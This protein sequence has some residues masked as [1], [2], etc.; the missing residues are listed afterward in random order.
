MKQKIFLLIGIVLLSI[1]GISI[2]SEFMANHTYYKDMFANRQNW[3]IVIRVMIATIIPLWYIIKTKTFS[4]KRFFV[5]ILPITIL[6]FSLAHTIIKEGIVGGS[7]GFLIL[8]VNSLLLYF[9]GMFFI[10][11]VLALGTWISNRW[12]K[13]KEFRWQEM[14]INFGIGLGI[15][16]LL[17]YVL[18]FVGLFYPAITWI[19]FL[20]L[21]GMIYLMRNKLKEYVPLVASMFEGFNLYNLRKNRWKWIGIILLGVS[22]IY[23]LYGFQLSFIPYSTAWDA[24]HAYMYLPKVLAE[25]AGILRGNVGP[26]SSA[27]GLR[28]VF[29]SFRFSLIQPIKSRFWLA[30]DTIAVA[31]NFLSGIFVLV[32]GL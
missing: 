29:I 4:L 10:V 28:H 8:C 6:F 25:N 24:N 3:K 14:V 18:A 26:L 2:F 17:G 11:G 12:I 1:F 27:P 20:G 23:Y 21:A 7:A 31:M 13:F 19:L 16:L 9:L 15:L 30:P 22:I 5:W 32:F